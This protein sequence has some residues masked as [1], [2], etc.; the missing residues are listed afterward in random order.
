MRF[1]QPNEKGLLQGKCHRCSVLNQGID[2]TVES[3]KTLS[4]IWSS[5]VTNKSH[6]SNFISS[7]TTSQC[8][9]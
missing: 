2:T 3:L 9:C 4:G 7:T 8:K 1:Q 5:N 6:F